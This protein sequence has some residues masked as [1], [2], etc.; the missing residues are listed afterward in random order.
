MELKQRAKPGVAWYQPQL[1]A[2]AWLKEVRVVFLAGL[3]GAEY[4]LV[5]LEGELFWLRPKGVALIDVPYSSEKASALAYTRALALYDAN[6]L[7]RV[8]G[9]Q[10]QGRLY[11]E[12]V[13]RDTEVFHAATKELSRAYL[14]FAAKALDRK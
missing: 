3:D 12:A 6:L 9:A 4:D 13:A 8:H 1:E 5:E 10:A 7:G 14:N 11:R 2:E